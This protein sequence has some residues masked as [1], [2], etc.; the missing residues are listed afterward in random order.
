M[1]PSIRLSLAF[2]IALCAVLPLQA[3]F[4]L[5]AVVNGQGTQ[6]SD[7]GAIAMNAPAVGQSVT[8]TLTITYLDQGS[9]MFPSQAQLMGSTSFSD[10]NS[11][12]PQ[13]LST[14]QSATVTFV[15]TAADTSA[16][17]AVFT[18]PFNVIVGGMTTATG[19]LNLTLVGTAPNLVVGEVISGTFTPVSAGGTVQFP[20]TVVNSSSLVNI[21][22]GNPG[23][24]T[25]TINSVTVSGS[26]YSAQNLPVLP[27]TLNAGGQLN[28][29]LQFLPVAAGASQG[30][31]QINYANGSASAVLM[32]TGTS[33]I[34][35]LGQI[36]S[37]G[38]FSPI[39]AGGTVQFMNTV[40]NSA[41]SITIAISNSGSVPAIVNSVTATGAAY[42]AQSLPLFPL[43]LPAG[44]QFTF[45]VQFLPVAA[46]V[47]QGSLQ[48]SYATGSA[49]AVLMGTGLASFFT[50]QITQTG[51]T[52]PLLPNQTIAFA[53]TTIGATSTATIQFQNADNLALTF[54]AIGISGAAFTITDAPFLPATLQPQQ[55][56]SITVTFAPTQPGPFTGRLEIGSD[57]FFLSGV[58]LGSALQFSSQT[59]GATVTVSPG[60]TVSFPLLQIGQQE[61]IQFSMQNTGT[62]TTAVPSIGL[63]SSASGFQLSGLPAFPLQLAPNATATFTIQFA[64]VSAGQSATTLLVGGQGF[65]LSGFASAPALSSFQFTGASGVQQPF[66]QPAIG[67]TLTSPYPVDLSGSLT[68]AVTSNNF[69][70]DP[71]VQFS[72]GGQH[73]AFTIPANTLQAVFP[74]GAAQIRLQTGTVAG[75]IVISPDF[76]VGTPATDITPSNAPSLQLTVPSLAPVL[77]TASIAST[78][79]TSLSLVV[80]GYT[81][82]RSLNH[83]NFQFVAASG[84]SIG[85]TTATV[86]VSAASQLWFES[87][88]SQSAGGE[89]TVEIP[90]SFSSSATVTATTNL[91]A[92]LSAISVTAA[93]AVGTSNSLT[94]PVL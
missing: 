76:T 60:G 53:G 41:S 70:T 37:S 30:T 7:G 4:N 17:S 77:L 46:G 1:M 20:N 71:A 26:G 48:V 62:T 43:T 78:T 33:P 13:S 32:G 24:G 12:G 89:F 28:F 67:L 25:A 83:L 93:N 29:A 74:G 39:P 79:A 6:V 22:I 44:S 82:T 21:S 81:T 54:S 31:L 58:G 14:F 51:Q 23:S 45:T 59:G 91:T 80:T 68:M 56:G 10:G 88:P 38:N 18:W 50:Y 65:I 16:D 66:Q 19:S 94:V 84:V 75:T 34:P 47:S 8:A 49:S 57:T 42:S 36:N 64:P 3:Q 87:T 90:F 40:V 55:T 85:A 9:V 35:V 72:S 27:V 2:G 52:S 92:N 63:A 15:Y 11:A 5:T 86:D 61:S 73:V 69:F